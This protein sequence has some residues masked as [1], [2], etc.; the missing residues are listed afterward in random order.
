MAL[1][2]LVVGLAT[3]AGAPTHAKNEKISVTV[4]QS[5]THGFDKPVSTVSVADSKIADVVVAG[6]REVLINGKEIGLTTLV[7]WDED[8]VSSSY[9][10]IVRGPFSDQQIELRVKLAEV[11]RSRIEELGMDLLFNDTDEP[12]WTA[13]TYSGN[14]STPSIPLSL[15]GDR[16]TEGLTGAI[17]YLSGGV[18]VQAMV[19]ALES[20]GVIR[21]LAE[22]N[23]V[24]ASGGK[25]NFL[26]GGEIPVPIASAGTQGG[27]TVTIEWKE[28]GVKVN[29]I[30]TI[31]DD[32][33]INLDLTTEVSSL[34]FGNGIDLSGF[35]IPALR[36]R[37]A[38][39]DAN[40]GSP[41][42]ERTY[43]HYRDGAHASGVSEDH[44]CVFQWVA[45]VHAWRG[46]GRP[47]GRDRN[48]GAIGAA[49]FSSRRQPEWRRW[50]S[51]RRN[52]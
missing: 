18:D 5:V 19:N 34:D 50:L 11:N 2:V 29:F 41:F 47:A 23:V 1:S 15:F 35:R 6:A 24:A 39:T 22:P 21:L 30:P 40:F 27:S 46:A 25:A 37:R 36:T 20:K 44:A 26:S 12:S 38:D 14:V 4:G 43:C 3:M 51:R 45:V 10:I 8:Q 9:D 32:G 17:R 49:G 48:R 28:F 7:V 42:L 16:S 13:G 33:V 31:V 52:T